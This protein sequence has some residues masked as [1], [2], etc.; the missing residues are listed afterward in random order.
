M[1]KLLVLLL[2]A[3]LGLGLVAC[4][5]NGNEKTPAP[6][7]TIDG[8]EDTRDEVYGVYDADDEEVA[9]YASLYA[10]I[11][12]C[13][14]EGDTGY[15]VAKD[16]VK[17]FVN[18]DCY[19][20]TSADMFWYYEN[21]TSVDTYSPWISTYWADAKETDLI[22]VYKNS[23]TGL[24]EPY[25]GSWNCISVNPTPAGQFPPGSTAV[26]NACWYLEAS[27]TVDMIAYSGIT[28]SEYVVDL[29][30][31]EI[32]PSYKGTDAAWAYVG[33]ITA[34]SYNT[35]N[36]GLRCDSTTGNWYYYEGETTYN[37]NAIEVNTDE[38]VLTS[39]WDETAGCWRPNND[40]TLT[41]ELLNLIDEDDC[42][43]IVHRLTIKVD[44]GKTIVHDYEY[45]GLSICGS[46]RFTSG[47]DIVSD[48]GLVD[49]MCGAKF[50][51]LTVVKATGTVLEEMT[52]DDGLAYTITPALA[53]G[54]YDL[55]NSNPMSE[56]RFHTIV[57][58]TA[59]VDTDFT[60]PGKD[61]YNYSFDMDNSAAP[62]SSQVQEVVDAIAA[63]TDDA[64]A[65]EAKALAKELTDYQLNLVYNKSILEEYVGSLQ[66][67]LTSMIVQNISD[68][69]VTEEGTTSTLAFT[70][71]S[72]WCGL[73]LYYEGV[74]LTKDNV[75]C[76]QNVTPAYS[77]VIYWDGDT[78]SWF[79]NNGLGAGVVYT[80]VYDAATNTLS[81]V[82]PA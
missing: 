9:T 36:L 50:E 8:R 42:E 61:V 55:L 18:N 26:W 37:S 44:G 76:G 46:I 52:A 5:D 56:A 73:E 48:N 6:S 77:A 64:S 63:I 33:F 71:T 40:V 24:L 72:Q 58:N 82:L 13:V 27:A 29:T 16:G 74:K 7:I 59:C 10:A 41:M 39:T 38:V 45:S 53:T 80:L 3:V 54:S 43:Y 69:V 81:C 49:Y 11:N 60:T 28:K 75:T 67:K 57:Y 78:N 51:K 4:V 65:A 32:T 35:S 62:L 22:A 15:Y 20:E 68:V 70:C 79:I 34:D 23:G 2:T 47:L 30:A 17:M 25:A 21:G 12:N 14:D 31:A 66:N 1:K 19:D